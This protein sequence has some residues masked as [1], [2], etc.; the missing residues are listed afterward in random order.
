MIRKKLSDRICLRDAKDHVSRLI[1]RVPSNGILIVKGHNLEA[2]FADLTQFAKSSVK[3]RR[4]ESVND[5]LRLLSINKDTLNVIRGIEA[6]KTASKPVLLHPD[7]HCR[8]LF[9]DPSDPAQ[10]TGIIDWQ[11]TAIE[12]A[13]VHVEEIPDIAQELPLDKT[14]DAVQDAEMDAAQADAQ[15]CAGTWAAMAYLCPKLGEAASALDPL[16]CRYMAAPSFGW[17]DDMVPILSLLTD[18][19]RKWADLGLPDRSLYQPSEMDIQALNVQ[20]DELESMQRLKMYLVRLLGC[21]TDGWVNVERWEEVLPIYR[22]QYEQ[23]KIAC[24]ASREEGE[25]E[26]EAIERAERLWPFDQ[27]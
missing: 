16:L 22:E 20:L 23:F 21:E 19:S 14:L 17:L 10:I 15:R 26:D 2:Y 25:N 8:N 11:A 3:E 18:L 1:Y 27:R 24:I 12:P 6:V 13:F 9:V 5:H 4:D 7:F